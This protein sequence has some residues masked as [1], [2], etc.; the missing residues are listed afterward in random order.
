MC[1]RLLTAGDGT[2]V[3]IRPIEAQDRKRLQDSFDQLS[4]ESRH[5]RFFGPMHGLTGAQLEYLTDVDHHDHEALVALE[6]D[7]ERVIGVARY[8]RTAPTVAEPAV[9]VIDEWQGRGIGG[10][11]LESLVERARDEGIDVFCA[12]VLADNPAPLRLLAQ[13]GEVTVQ[14][15]GS[16][17]EIEVILDDPQPGPLRVLLRGVAA[18]TFE[19]AL[20][21]WRRLTATRAV[22]QVGDRPNVIVAAVPSRSTDV[23]ELPRLAGE[24]AGHWGAHVVLVAGGRPGSRMRA[25][26]ARLEQLVE[27]LEASGTKASATL[28]VGDLATAVLD[29]AT[30]EHAR[31]I[32]VEDVAE[33]GVRF[34]GPAWD[35]ISH[36]APCDVL[37]ARH[38]GRPA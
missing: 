35:H 7:E 12:S 37:V 16:V 21:W 24:L 10:A 18:G 25:D 6:G 28:V 31:L 11:L 22:T 27:V 5:R 1:A 29:V 4:P 2:P 3:S 32:V 15:G 26:E 20:D 9:T 23:P 8:V 34:G 17:C 13:A 19:P 36:H 33:P 30:V 38:R 14:R